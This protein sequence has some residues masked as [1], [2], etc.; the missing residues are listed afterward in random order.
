MPVIA[1]KGIGFPLV[2]FFA[3]YDD[4]GV[5][6]RQKAIAAIKKKALIK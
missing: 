1:S 4:S 2:D 5:W 3:G 6:I